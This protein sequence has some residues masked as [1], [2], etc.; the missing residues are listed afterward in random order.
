M[1]L[2]S[3]CVELPV[4]LFPVNG[5]VP[6]FA[7]CTHFPSSS[8]FHQAG[9]SFLFYRFQLYTDV[10]WK[11]GAETLSQNNLSQIRGTQE[12]PCR[13]VGPRGTLAQAGILISLWFWGA[14]HH[15]DRAT[16]RHR[17]QRHPLQQHL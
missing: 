1:N 3:V 7:L 17:M 13:G 6:Y 15:R 9:F 5:I 16:H 4:C 12:T 2:L 8:G 14:T 11:E 10:S